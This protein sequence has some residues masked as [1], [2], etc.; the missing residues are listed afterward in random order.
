MKKLI[1]AL[2][3]G[4]ASLGMSAQEVADSTKKVVLPQEVEMLDVAGKLV[5]YG[6]ENGEAL[7]LIQ[8]VEIYRSVG[9]K[10]FQGQKTE[11]GAAVETGV[12]AGSKVSYD[13]SQI[14]ADA[15]QLAEGDTNLLA[16]IDGLK[17]AEPTRGATRNYDVHTD[18]VRAGGTDV[19]KISFRGGEQAIV[20]VSGDGDTD[21]DLYVYD[22]NGN[23]VASDYDYTD[24]CVASW[25]PRWTG[26]FTIKIMNRG[27]VYNRYRMAVN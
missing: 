21:L 25:T 4:T 22:S 12:K 17:N 24:D 8:A 13:L 2:M 9:T 26:E 10:D 6:Y 1:V 19:Y 23:C 20:V 14:L 18:T 16:L 3:I 7:P 11:E 5:K 27:N 15:A